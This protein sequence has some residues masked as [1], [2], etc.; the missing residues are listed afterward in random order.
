MLCVSFL[1]NFF[2][3]YTMMSKK[4]KIGGCFY[5]DDR[6]EATDSE[7][8]FCLY[9]RLTHACQLYVVLV[10]RAYDLFGQRWDRQAL[11]SAITGCREIH[12]I[13]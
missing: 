8:L 2:V 11:V 13:R 9:T 6:D 10:P 3:G 4:L 1:I 5:T 12:D 7:N